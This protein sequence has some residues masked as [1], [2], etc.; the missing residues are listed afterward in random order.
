MCIMQG[1]NRACAFC[2]TGQ[3]GFLRNLSADEILAQ[4][5]HARRAARVENMVSSTI[6]LIQLYHAVCAK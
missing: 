1:C 5:Y 6:H 2:A 4:V 3:M